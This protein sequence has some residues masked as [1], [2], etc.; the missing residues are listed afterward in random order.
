MLM[1]TS[2]VAAL[3]ASTSLLPAGVTESP[4]TFA[5]PPI[6]VTVT[7]AGVP[8][9]LLHNVFDEA[10]AIWKG[11]GISFVWRIAER[12]PRPCQV[13]GPPPLPL[14]LRVTF[15]DAPGAVKGGQLPLGWIVFDDVTTPEQEIY[16]SYGN[17]MRFLKSARGVV[18]L[19]DQM[20][21]AQKETL[22]GRAMGRALA[23]EIGHYLL[24]SKIH[25]PKG[26]MKAT[27]TAFEFFTPDRTGFIIEAGQTQVLV[28]RLRNENRTSNQ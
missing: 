6:T 28:A 1:T 5:A 14:S 21:Q 10:D 26:L 7:A 18:G 2:L 24:A 25:T 12:D 22:L 16:V 17:A 15:G 8:P 19:L 13:D 11:S 9:S 20:P 3:I 27:R 23:H 4:A